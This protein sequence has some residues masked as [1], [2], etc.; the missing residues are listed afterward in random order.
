MWVSHSATGDSNPPKLEGIICGV[1]VLLLKLMPAET[2]RSI[3]RCFVHMTSVSWNG[4]C[5]SL[6]VL[7]RTPA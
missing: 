6:L 1:Y 4:R 7:R 2:R 5:L 3:G